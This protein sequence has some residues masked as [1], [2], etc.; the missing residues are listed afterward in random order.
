MIRTYIQTKLFSC[1]VCFAAGSCF[2]SSDFV[3]TFLSRP[4]PRKSKRGVWQVSTECRGAS[5]TGNCHNY[6]LSTI[7]ATLSAGATTGES[8]FS[9]HRFNSHSLLRPAIVR[10]SVARARS[11]GNKGKVC[12]LSSTGEN[13]TFSWSCTQDRVDSTRPKVYTR[14]WSLGGKARTL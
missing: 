11:V 14:L 9:M 1:L 12:S 4:Q 7:T 3:F 2:G 13:S 10:R 6:T 8:R 5:P